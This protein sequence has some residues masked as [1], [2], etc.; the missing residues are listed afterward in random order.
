MGAST[1]PPTPLTD[2]GASTWPPSPQRSGR[3]GKAVAPLDPALGLVAYRDLRGSVRHGPRLRQPRGQ[4]LAGTGDRELIIAIATAA[5][6][7]ELERTRP[8]VIDLQAIAV[9]VGEVE[10]A[11]AHVIDRA[12]DGHAVLEQRRVSVLQRL[13]V[14]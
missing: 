4:G 8:L 11:L 5:V 2:M 6:A 13:V 12:V 9:R 10:A 7:E 3:P 14:S 1:W